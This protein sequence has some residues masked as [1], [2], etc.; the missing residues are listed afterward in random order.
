MSNTGPDEVSR[1]HTLRKIYSG[2]YDIA[3]TINGIYGYQIILDWAYDF[4]SL[5]SFL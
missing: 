2:L 5:V 4:V 1:I 3:E